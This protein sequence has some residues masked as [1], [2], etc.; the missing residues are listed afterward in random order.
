MKEQ[1]LAL[2]AKMIDG[3]PVSVKPEIFNKLEGREGWA[4]NVFTIY[5]I[6][7][8]FITIEQYGQLSTDAV[9]YK[10]LIEVLPEEKEKASWL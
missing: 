2:C 5:D 3:I 10:D 6:S 8:T 7:N 9:T 1:I 4:E